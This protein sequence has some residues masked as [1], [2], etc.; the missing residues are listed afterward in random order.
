MM[1]RAAS[2]V[3]VCLGLAGCAGSAQAPGG[4]VVA[5]PAPALLAEVNAA[6]SLRSVPALPEASALSRAAATHA[7]DMAAKGYFAHN[8]P[9][10]STPLRRMRAAGFDAC[11]ATE[12][13][14]R[15]QRTEP[16][17]VESW[18]K[19]PEDAA[20]IFSPNPTAAGAARFGT[21]WVVTLSRPC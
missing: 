4:A 2:C 14:A 20:L 11:Y 8:A 10:G 3:L 12:T 15:G 9:D 16:E 1:L 7:E 19:S 13:I 5:G 17:V 21:F 6:R 18:I